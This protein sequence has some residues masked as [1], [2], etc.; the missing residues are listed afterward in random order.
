MNLSSENAVIEKEN[1]KPSEPVGRRSLFDMMTD[2]GEFLFSAFMAIVNVI[3][4]FVLRLIAAFLRGFERLQGSFSA[5]FKKAAATAGSPFVRYGK[6]LKM[7]SAEISKARRKKGFFGG[8]AA[9]ARVAGRIIFG[10]RGLAVTAVNWVLPIASCVFLF[11]IISYANSQAYALKLTINGDL[12][13][14][15]DDE[16]VYI[17]AEKIVQRRINY[18]GSHTE[19]VTF[20]PVY[21]V[22]MVGYGSTF[23]KYQLADKMLELLDTDIARGYG[24]YIGDAYFGTLVDQT[25]VDATLE[26]LLNAYRTGNEKESVSFERQI[27][28][29]PGVYLADSFVDEDDLIRTLTSKKSV[30]TYY[31]VEEGDSPSKVCTKTDMTYEELGRLNPDFSESSNLHVGDKIAITR[32]EPFLNII[33]TREE[34]YNEAI[35]YDTEYEEDSTVYSGNKMQRRDG[36]DGERAVTANVSYINDVEISR[37]V[38]TR[39]TTLSPVSEIYAIGTKPRPADAASGQTIGVGKMLWPVGGNGGHVTEQPASH[40]GY[41]GHNGVDIGAPYYTPVYA[42]ENG[43][44]TFCEYGYNGGYGN[45]IQIRG[46]SGYVTYYGHMSELATY[47]GARVTAGDLIGYV[48]STGRSSGNHLHFEV[49]LYGIVL[50]PLD[51]ID[52]PV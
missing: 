43:I 52:R 24:L 44:V 8:F 40:G 42:A 23:N 15:I 28:F 50:Y 30:A 47:E 5:A 32:D 27:T 20:A 48:G 19:I 38:L 14:Y 13:G 25:K 51:F 2:L 22:D 35:P 39:T 41:A 36:V 9:G 37:R 1:R 33:V 17:E 4:E 31:T 3:V 29:T 18:T 49:R 11:N 34:H 10:K 21:E 26:S 7:G 46:D 45:H 12:V 16:T 6:A